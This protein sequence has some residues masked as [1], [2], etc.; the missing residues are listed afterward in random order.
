MSAETCDWC[1]QP[2]HGAV[3]CQ[4]PS[5]QL[6]DSDRLDRWISRL[7]LGLCGQTV[8][9]ILAQILRSWP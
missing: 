2:L 4:R 9:G 3:Y 7:G 8:L 5:C 6:P 1:G